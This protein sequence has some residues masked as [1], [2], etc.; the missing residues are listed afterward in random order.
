MAPDFVLAW[1]TSSGENKPSLTNGGHVVFVKHPTR[2][3]EIPGG[4]LEAGESPEQALLREVLEETGLHVSIIEWNK[5]YYQNGWVASVVTIEKPHQ[6]SWQVNDLK[7][8][9]IKWWDSV[10][11]VIT[12]TKQEFIDLDNWYSNL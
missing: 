5:E 2:G 8:E 4:H 10:P 7:V 6:K 3:W 11:P 1:I 12:W 9:E